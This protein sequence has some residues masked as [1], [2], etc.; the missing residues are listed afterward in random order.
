MRGGARR[1]GAGRIG[2]ALARDGLSRN[3]KGK[4]AVQPEY[5][6]ALQ[7]TGRLL[8]SLGHIVEEDEV[9]IDSAEAWRYFILTGTVQVGNVRRHPVTGRAPTSAD[10]ETVT[11]D[12]VQRASSIPA[13][14]YVAA[15]QFARSAGRAMGEYHTRHDV[16]ITP[17]LAQAPPPTGWLSMMQDPQS[18]WKKL[19]E[20]SPFGLWFSL[21]GQPAITLPVAGHTASGV[22]LSVQIVAPYGGE[23]VLFRI[24]AQIEA[25]MPWTYP[26]SR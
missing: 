11:F 23:A 7:A 5:L 10:L 17:A 6:Q 8:Q 2:R 24:A 19:E 26:F 25:A 14:D 18:Y 4:I 12:M 1:G 13:I 21:T 20:F 22:P 3:G 15:I 16:V 9:P